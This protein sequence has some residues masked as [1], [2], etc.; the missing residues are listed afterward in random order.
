MNTLGE[1][2]L[3]LRTQKDW[4]QT[5][6]G[7]RAM[8]RLNRLGIAKKGDKKGIGQSTISDLETGT[9]STSAENLE[10][11][12]QELGTTSRYLLLGEDPSLQPI[13][14]WDSH[15]DLDSEQYA[16]I[17]RLDL[18]FMGGAGFDIQEEP[19]ILPVGSAFRREWLKSKK[20]DEKYL[21]I[22]DVDG[23]SYAP[24]VL[25]GSSVLINT[26]YNSLLEI[27]EG[28][29][30]CI[31]YGRLL[32]FKKLTFTLSGSLNLINGSGDIEEVVPPHDFEHI[33][34]FGR[35]VAHSSDS[36]L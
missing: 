9:K 11:I 13:V 7:R 25:P 16:I 22:V 26:R 2:L 18:T 19:Y 15:S 6:L 24:Y 4:S 29:V 35:Y 12:A 21:R 36:E 23:E 5:E 32:K 34:V 10:A 3:F 8:A 1:R 31:R 30:Y 33:Q 28:K 17:P 27:T 14:S 20:L